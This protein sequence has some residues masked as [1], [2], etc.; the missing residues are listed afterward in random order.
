MNQPPGDPQ[1]AADMAN[2]SR[3]RRLLDGPTMRYLK[4]RHGA[5]LLS[6]DERAYLGQLMTLTEL[7]VEGTDALLDADADA[8]GRLARLIRRGRRAIRRARRMGRA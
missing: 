6:D 1:L 3:F 4:E 2:L 7:A 8:R 5:G